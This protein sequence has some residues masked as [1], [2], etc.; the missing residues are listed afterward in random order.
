MHLKIASLVVTLLLPIVSGQES[1][2][3]GS[4]TFPNT[5]YYAT[6]C[7]NSDGTHTNEFWTYFNP[8]STDPRN[9]DSKYYSDPNGNLW[10]EGNGNINVPLDSSGNQYRVLL[11]SDAAYQNDAAMVGALQSGDGSVTYPCYRTPQDQQRVDFFNGWVC[12]RLYVCSTVPHYVTDVAI[13]S[14]QVTLAV[15]QDALFSPGPY[16]NLF[17]GLN[18]QLSAANGQISLIPEYSQSFTDMEGNTHSYVAQVENNGVYNLYW[19]VAG[20]LQSQSLGTQIDGAY[21]TA[22]TVYGDVQF[23]Q[24]ATIVTYVGLDHAAYSKIDF[25]QSG[26]SPAPPAGTNC[27]TQGFSIGSGAAGIVSGVL[28]SAAVLA[29][30]ETGGIS[31]GVAAGVFGAASGTLGIVSSVA[32]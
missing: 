26:F 12:Y 7:Y 5:K 2:T 21:N 28:G 30:P 6:N 14:Q 4:Q 13:S 20:A 16:E 29:A 17:S 15:G 10:W 3:V 27:N 9:P 24:S 19:T 11:S 31:L 22:G 18:G 1:T 32:C 25:Y 8:S 23:P